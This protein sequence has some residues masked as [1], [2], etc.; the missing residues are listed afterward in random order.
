MA[1][2]I[3]SVSRWLIFFVVVF[4]IHVH[5]IVL[6]SVLNRMFALIY[7]TFRIHHE[8][9]YGKKGRMTQR[10]KQARQTFHCFVLNSHFIQPSE[11]KYVLLV[12]LSVRLQVSFIPLRFSFGQRFAFRTVDLSRE[13]RFVPPYLRFSRKRFEIFFRGRCRPRKLKSAKNNPHLF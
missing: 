9:F 8:L 1:E 3:Y 2:P 11:C 5:A 7:V 4:V 13:S 6:V 12:C 10:N